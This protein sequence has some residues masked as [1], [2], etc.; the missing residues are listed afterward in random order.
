MRASAAR[1]ALVG[2]DLEPIDLGD[3]TNVAR[4]RARR[5]WTLPLRRRPY[6]VSLGVGVVAVVAV[7]S[8][9]AVT[10]SHSRSPRAAAVPTTLS[11]QA[12]NSA[13]SQVWQA[14]PGLAGLAL[15]PFV[16]VVDDAVVLVSADESVRRLVSDIPGSPFVGAV[17]RGAVLVLYG[18]EVRV[19]E[20]VSGDPERDTLP[21][22][23]ALVPDV[24]GRWWSNFGE[25]DT[26]SALRRIAV[27]GGTMPVAKLRD[28]Y[29]LVDASQNLLEWSPGAPLRK[30]ADGHARVLAIADDLVAWSDD[31]GDVTRVTSLST[32]RTRRIPTGGFAISARFSPDRS[33]IAILLSSTNDSM[34][35][36]DTV[37]GSVLARV[38]TAVPG[39]GLPAFDNIALAFEPVPFSWGPTGRQLVVVA[40]RGSESFIHDLDTNGAVTRTK[41]GPNGLKQLLPL[42]P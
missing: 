32:T 7:V 27:P 40:R 24:A 26:G 20:R 30:I 25:L 17:S 12:R 34:V 33:R 37:T 41:T 2:E 6:V 13:S 5:R 3:E 31:S 14:P 10:R 23:L 39:R 21:A 18:S 9:V 11:A 42:T 22:A 1:R 19:I 8:L 36:A 35:L 38:T 4:A 29:L 16:A 15:R 28:G